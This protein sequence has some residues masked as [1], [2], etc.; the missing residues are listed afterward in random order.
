MV[1]V[2]GGCGGG[3]IINNVIG[4]VMGCDPSLTVYQPD[5]VYDWVTLCLLEGSSC[6]YR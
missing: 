6:R 5:T 1:V 2:G 3:G 4:S